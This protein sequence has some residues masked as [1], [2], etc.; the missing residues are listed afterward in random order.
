MKKLDKI[1]ITA[2]LSGSVLA[3]GIDT[4]NKHKSNIEVEQRIKSIQSKYNP[5]RM[6]ETKLSEIRQQDEFNKSI[7]EKQQEIVSYLNSDEYKLREST[8]H[9]R[10]P[11]GISINQLQP[12]TMEISYYSDLNCENGY[13]NLTATGKILSPGMIANNHLSFG[14]KVY[15]EG[16]GMKIVEDRGSKKYFPTI[17]SCDVFVPRIKGESDSQYYKRVNNMGRHYKQ[18]Y[19]IK[20][21]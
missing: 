9:W 14:S 18:S 10:E 13:G 16:E 2:I 19:I 20:E 5:R 1:I 21:M 7:K 12:I 8:R 6:L 3:I 4:Y 17:A 11:L 15:I